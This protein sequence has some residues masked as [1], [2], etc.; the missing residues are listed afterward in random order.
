MD[1]LQQEFTQ[2]N[3]HFIQNY[4]KFENAVQADFEKEA[5]LPKYNEIVHNISGM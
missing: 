5:E 2:Q 1:T 3:Q 4:G